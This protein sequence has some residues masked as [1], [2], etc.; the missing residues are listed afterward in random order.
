MDSIETTVTAIHD[1]G[2]NAVAIEI[3]TPPGFSA[4]PGQ[5]VKL[6]AT[7][8]DETVARFYTV[9]SRDTRNT[10]ELTVSYD[11]EEGGELSEYLLSLSSGDSITIT[12]PFGDD[13]YE[14]EPRVVVLA[15]GP[16]IGPAVAIAERALADGHEAAVVYRDDDPIHEDRLATSEAGGADVFVL[17]DETDLTDAVADVLT[18]DDGE[19][20]FIYGFADFLGDAEAAIEAAGGDPDA[21]KAENF[22]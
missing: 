18:N 1:V 22:G 13:Y 15:G 11:P 6:S 12:G 17:A 14:G 2:T 7:I 20:V 8:D 21:A 10:F 4:V 16:G 3:T 5:F 19:Q 9:S